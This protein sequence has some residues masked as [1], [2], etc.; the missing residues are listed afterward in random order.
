M[1]FK[2]KGRNGMKDFT[3]IQAGI[4]PIEEE[5]EKNKIYEIPEDKIR[6]GDKIPVIFRLRANGLWEE[7][8]STKKI[9]TPKKEVKKPEGDD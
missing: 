3:L 7:V 4:L 6:S 8:Q 2:F 9:P 5:L 1:K